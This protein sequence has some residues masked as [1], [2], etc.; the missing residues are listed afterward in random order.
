M[1]DARRFRRT[2]AFSSSAWFLFALD[3][4]VVTTAVPAIRTDLRTDV[5]DTTWI[6][7]AYPLAF[8]VLLLSGAALG[9]RFGRRR[10]FTLGMAIFTGASALAAVAPSVEVL[11]AARAIQ[12][13]GGAIFTPLALA[14]LAA[15]T[16]LTDA[17][18]SWAPGAPSAAWASPPVRSWVA[19]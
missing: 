9:D 10:M 3:R 5:A 12:G 2:F 14:L 16:R 1:T 11:V 6:V 8:A 7:N 17:A 18:A 15:V 13:A 19:C 4:L